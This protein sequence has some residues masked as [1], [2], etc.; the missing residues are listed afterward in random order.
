MWLRTCNVIRPYRVVVTTVPKEV[1]RYKLALLGVQEF[2]C[3]LHVTICYF[4][5]NLTIIQLRD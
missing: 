2:G 1:V 4:Y 5:K 3:F